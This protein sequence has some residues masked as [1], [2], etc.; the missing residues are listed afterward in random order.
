MLNTMWKICPGEC[1]NA[2]VI[3]RHGSATVVTG[4]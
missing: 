3:I 1:R 2:T 4:A